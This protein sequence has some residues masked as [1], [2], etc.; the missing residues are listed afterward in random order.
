MN[1]KQ[2]C[3]EIFIC[4]NNSTSVGFVGK[5]VGV[6]NRACSLGNQSCGGV[7]PQIK[8]GFKI[9]VGVTRRNVANI[10]SG[11][12]VDPNFSSIKNERLEQFKVSVGVLIHIF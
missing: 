10:K 4:A 6:D 1:A 9:A 2:R 7:I 8:G 11:R 12:S 3:N 5:R